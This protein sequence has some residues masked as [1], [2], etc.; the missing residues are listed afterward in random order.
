MGTSKVS[1][2]GERNVT[3]RG[4]LKVTRTAFVSVQ[5]GATKETCSQKNRVG[6]LYHAIYMRVLTDRPQRRLEHRCRNLGKASPFVVCPTR[7]LISFAANGQGCLL[8]DIP[9]TSKLATS[10]FYMK[11]TSLAPTVLVHTELCEQKKYAYLVGAI[12]RV[13]T[14]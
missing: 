6:S 8:K 2:C 1:A 5:V 11:T 4:R 7:R 10:A 14:A 13:L 3:N 9:P 12:L